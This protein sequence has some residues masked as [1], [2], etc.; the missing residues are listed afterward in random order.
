M[1]SVT[2][3][4]SQGDT[5]PPIDLLA[6]GLEQG[7]RQ[8]IEAALEWIAD[9]YEGKVLGTGEATVKFDIDAHA[10]TASAKS[11]IEAAGGT[12]NEL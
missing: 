7:E 10:Y 8:R 6:A 5:A 12:A 9:L 1:V 2:H 4:I 3:A 11:K